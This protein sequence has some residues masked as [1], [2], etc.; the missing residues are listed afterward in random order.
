MQNLF[1]GISKVDS[2]RSFVKTTKKNG[3][4]LKT[5]ELNATIAA[6]HD[7]VKLLPSEM[8]I[9]GFC[10]Q[11]YKSCTEEIM[12]EIKQHRSL[13]TLDDSGKA[14]AFSYICTFPAKIGTRSEMYYHGDVSPD[15][16]KAHILKHCE[17]VLEVVKTEQYALR[18]H[19][20]QVPREIIKEFMTELG[21]VITTAR[22]IK[23]IIE[24]ND[25]S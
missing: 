16:L 2:L 15:I 19:F 12:K 22:G 7:L 20:G 14:L 25:L 5:K 24:V 1:A 6:Q 13:I 17:A 3:F 8:F 23:D 9:G 18:M 11:V 4:Y 21:F 10:N